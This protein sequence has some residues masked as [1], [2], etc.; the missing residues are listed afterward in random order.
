MAESSQWNGDRGREA[1]FSE[2]QK[3]AAGDQKDIIEEWSELHDKGKECEREK[4]TSQLGR[5]SLLSSVG[6]LSSY[7]FDLRVRQANAAPW[8]NMSDDV[9][10][11]QG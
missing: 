6:N 11:S 3:E 2:L 7:P 1:F 9:P 8:R 10:H 4:V 5:T